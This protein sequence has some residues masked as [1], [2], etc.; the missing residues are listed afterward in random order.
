MTRSPLPHLVRR[1]LARQVLRPG[2]S[3]GLAALTAAVVVGLGTRLP[4]GAPEISPKADDK[5]TV[6]TKVDD[7][8]PLPAG[9]VHRFGNRLARHPDGINGV[10]VSPDGKLAATIG[11]SSVIVWDLK[12]MAAKCILRDQVS[13]GYYG[14]SG[15]RVSF[16]PDS[17]HV[18]VAVYPGNNYYIQMERGQ[19]VEVARVYDVE[20]GKLKFAVRGDADYWTGAWLTA[21]GKEIAV[22]AQQAV[23]FH[24]AT[25]GKELRKV[26]CGP[27]LNGLLAVAPE[28][29]LLAM[30][31]NDNNTLILV[32][33]TTGKRPAELT[34]ENMGR[35]ALTPDGKRL[36]V[37]DG[38]NKIHIHDLEANKELFAFAQPGNN[39]VAQMQF[40]ADKR[41][42]YFGGRFG[43][44]FRWDLKTNK[45]LPDV[46]QHSTWSLTSLVVSPDETMLYSTA[47]DKLIKRWDLKTL[48]EIPAPDGYITQTAVVPLP[49]RRTMLVAD[50]QGALD[51]WDLLSGKHLG[52]LQEQKSGGIDCVAVSADGRWFAGGRTTQDVTLW[53][54]QAGKLE[55]IIPL[56]EKPDGKGSDHVRRVAFSG[57]GKVLFTGSQKTGITAWEVPTGKKVWNAPG[58]GPYLAVD[59]K[60]RWVAAGGGYNR[61]QVQWTLLSQVTG[62]VL[63]RVDV[64]PAERTEVQQQVFV[65][66]PAYLGDLRFTPDGSRLVTSHYDQALRV[67]EPGTGREVGRLTGT[68]HGGGL[69]I[70]ADGRWAGVGQQDKKITVWELASGKKVLEL[71]GHDSNVRDVAFTP[72]GKGIIGNADLAP[73]LWALDPRDNAKPDA[74][75]WD[76]LASDDGAKAYRAQWALVRDPAAAVKLL[77]E[78]VKPAELAL[79]R[80]KFDQWVADLDS[81]QFR[82][83]EAAER[84]LTRSGLRVP[85]GWL[86]K[87]LAE[88]K[89]DEPRARLGRVLAQ[90]EKPNPEE[91]RLERA[92]QVLELAGTPE[93]QALLKTWAGIESPL[94]DDSRGALERL[95]KRW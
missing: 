94:A 51:R 81:P 93:A 84:E 16:F 62:E 21:K 57:D 30:R 40:S 67:W 49:D 42:L 92:V 14:D 17:R 31:R 28:V 32:D 2:R 48:K 89:G 43:R 25:S 34:V 86:R 10:T 58:V 3:V 91:W 88:S 39:P 29:S 85:L 69:A 1:A 5:T 56:V 71:T 52:R 60:G 66:Y 18:L 13:P 33:A 15:A 24:D 19:K 6:I 36:A 54:L 9:A 59:P 50:H 44:L 46:G 83:R 75:T 7:G 61:E 90:R 95:S 4:A 80:A 26:A 63:R 41:T 22:Y 8:I 78:K 87:A 65:R 27:E 73:V 45:K 55:R 70:S 72:D 47:N 74:A 53:D 20:T 82:L 23:T 37:S 38:A 35:V 64:I 11:Q 68:G 12:T 77:T 79:D 76:V